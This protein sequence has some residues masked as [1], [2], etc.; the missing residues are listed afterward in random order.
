MTNY[1]N[2]I[3]LRTLVLSC[4]PKPLLHPHSKHRP[5]H[6]GGCALYAVFSVCLM[7]NS[8]LKALSLDQRERS[9]FVCSRPCRSEPYIRP[10]LPHGHKRPCGICGL[11]THWPLIGPSAQGHPTE[12]NGPGPAQGPGKYA[13]EW[14]TPQCQLPP[15]SSSGLSPSRAA[16]REL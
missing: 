13:W 4:Q 6:V 12:N 9:Q 7:T 11:L 16:R 1:R 3:A 2:L 15:L 10:F 14:F 5:P 8:G